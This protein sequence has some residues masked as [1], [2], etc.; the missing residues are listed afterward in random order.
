MSIFDRQISVYNG[1]TDKVGTITYLRSFLYSKR[2]ISRILDLRAETDD[3][4]R[5]AI[6]LSLPMATVSG[7][8]S[9]SRKAEHLQAHS[10]YICLD[11]DGKDNPEVKL[12]KVREVLCSRPE[13]AY[14]GL[15]VGGNGMFAI[16]PLA[17]PD[18]HGEQFDALVEE[19]WKEYGIRLDPSCRDVCRL[20]ALSYDENPYVNEAAVPYEGMKVFELERPTLEPGFVLPNQT[21]VDRC[22][23]K[24]EQS[25][26]D[27][28]NSYNDWYRIGMA[29]AELG[30]T[31]RYY[32][33][34]VSRQ[35]SGYK[36][37]EADKK[38]TDCL[39]RIPRSGMGGRGPVGL[40]TFFSV[41]LDYGITYRKEKIV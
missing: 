32:F 17:W 38:F 4:R 13:V 16:L 40:A 25:G 15:S 26:I 19:F 11:I 23:E 18:R 37:A 2:H 8:F 14:A 29:L 27:I 5:K 33:H 21:K 10:G 3:A 12:T 1:V 34:A 35:Y 6:K 9:P 36:Y 30:E 31:G 28:T 41:C 39:R 20:R 24:I 7:V 22:V